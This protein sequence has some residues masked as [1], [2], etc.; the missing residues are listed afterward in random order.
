[1]SLYDD[2]IK[3]IPIHVQGIMHRLKPLWIIYQPLFK[4]NPFINY[5]ACFA[6]SPSF[7]VGNLSTLNRAK[8]SFLATSFTQLSL[9]IFHISQ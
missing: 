7:K 5:L 8:L 6:Y 9:G 4:Q 3:Y 1:M 2:E